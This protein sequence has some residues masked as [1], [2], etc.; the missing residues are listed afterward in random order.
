MYSHCGGNIHNNNDADAH[1]PAAH[2]MT[3]QE[4][5]KLL[6][7]AVPP[8]IVAIGVQMGPHLYKFADVWGEQLE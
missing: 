5:H 3:H 1:P 2:R 6:C 7:Q 8:A 4:N